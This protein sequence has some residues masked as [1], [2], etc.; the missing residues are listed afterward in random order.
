MNFDPA[1]NTIM[2]GRNDKI[3][4]RPQSFSITEGLTIED[5]K[6]VPKFASCSDEEAQEIINSLKELAR[7][8]YY[9]FENQ[10]VIFENGTDIADMDKTKVVPLHES[11]KRAA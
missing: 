11:R 3:L 1:K 5:V 7:I 8:S 9:I 6:A 10:L 2:T 4:S